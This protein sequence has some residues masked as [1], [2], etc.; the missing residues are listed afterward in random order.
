MALSLPNFRSP[1]KAILQGKDI[2]DLDNPSILNYN[3]ARCS[4]Q[5]VN[6]DEYTVFQCV[7]ITPTAIQNILGV[8]IIKAAYP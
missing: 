2:M 7:V 1:G 3:I 6:L 8:N 5:I 4:P